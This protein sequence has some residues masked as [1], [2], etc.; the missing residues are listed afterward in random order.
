MQKKENNRW[1]KS[2]AIELNR[3]ANFREN[4]A[5][6][7]GVFTVIRTAW[8][9]MYYIYIYIYIYVNTRRLII[10]NI[11]KF[12]IDFSENIICY[13]SIFLVIETRSLGF[14]LGWLGFESQWRC[15]TATTHLDLM[16]HRVV[17]K[18]DGSH[19]QKG[20]H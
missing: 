15:S 11:A 17:N 6:L 1:K 12:S 4:A 10:Y 19:T 16:A 3:L 14:L 18:I 7:H 13:F 9:F 8:D 2:S 20:T 5:V